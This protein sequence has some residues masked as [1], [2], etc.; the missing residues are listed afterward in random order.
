MVDLY[1]TGCASGGRRGE[2]AL[3]GDCGVVHI[4]Q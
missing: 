2:K 3:E 4:R 1:D